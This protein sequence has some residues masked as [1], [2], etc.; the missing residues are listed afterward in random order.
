M[1]IATH[2]AGGING[3]DLLLWIGLMYIAPRLLKLQP[4]KRAAQRA[5]RRLRPAMPPQEVT[6]KVA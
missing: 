4:R 1:D 6:L 2:A 3:I 5:T